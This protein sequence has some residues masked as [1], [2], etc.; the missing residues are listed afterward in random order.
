M[1]AAVLRRAP[2][3]QLCERG[4]RGAG[5]GRQG[6][7]GMNQRVNRDLHRLLGVD[8]G[9]LKALA[10]GYVVQCLSEAMERRGQP[11]FATIAV[12]ES[13]PPDTVC[14][15][16]DR[17][18]VVL[19]VTQLVDRKAAKQNANATRPTD[20]VYR[21]W[22]PERLLAALEKTI[23]KKDRKLRKMRENEFDRIMLVIHTD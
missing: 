5:C 7:V 13:D 18:R 19:E 9:E 14:R 6:R 15:D 11:P 3:P 21:A 1:G 8:W 17:N 23:R 12:A 4:R 10:E 22:N 2:A 16:H 20:L